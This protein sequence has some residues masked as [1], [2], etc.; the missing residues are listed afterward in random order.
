[1]SFLDRLLEK[2]RLPDPL[3]RA[4]IHQLLSRKLRVEKRGGAEVQQRALMDFIRELRGMPIAIKTREAND[5]HYEVPTEFFRLVL[6]PR[7]KYSGG[8][9]PTRHTTLAESEDAMLALSCERARLADGQRVLELGCGWG[10]L[11]LWMAEKYP[12]SRILGVSNSRTQREY[13]MAE[14]ARRGLGNVEILTANVAEIELPSGEF[15]RVVS[16]EMF[17]HM[18]NYELLL[19]KV[20]S[21]MKPEALLF[22][23]IFTHRTRAY[24]FEGTDPSDWITRYFFEG[25]TMPSDD[26]LVYFQDDLKLRD[27]WCV[28]GTHYARTSEAWLANMDRHAAEI[29]PILAR[30]YGAENETKWR[31]YWRVFFM[32][33]AGLWGYR[34]GEEW[35]VSHY[36]FAK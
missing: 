16:V 1:M 32:S 8:L 19:R 4:G 6:G 24:H 17:E 33:C 18:K 36:L 30:T 22:V 5:Q 34:Y 10:S 15:D 21:W 7:M 25:G 13:I 11:T 2:D 35:I 31:V 29:G 26:L 9:W 12:A 28:N 23:H 20:A 14:A 3:I 27:H